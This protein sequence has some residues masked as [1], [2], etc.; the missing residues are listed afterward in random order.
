MKMLTRYLLLVISTCF[1][2]AGCKKDQDAS[3]SNASFLQDSCKPLTIVFTPQI[4]SGVTGYS[5]CELEYTG[6]RITRVKYKYNTGALYGTEKF[7]FDS[8]NKLQRKEFY[9]NNDSQISESHNFY[10]A[11]DPYIGHFLA[12]ADSNYFSNMFQLTGYTGYI[13]NGGTFYDYITRIFSNN[14]NVPFKKVDYTWSNGD[15]VKFTFIEPNTNQTQTTTVTYDT[16]Q[17]NKLNQLY[18]DLSFLVI[19][20]DGAIRG[21]QY[22]MQHF[23]LGKHLITKISTTGNSYYQMS[24]NITYTYNAQGL[25]S[26]IKLDGLIFLRFT[27]SCD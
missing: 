13:Y 25:V 9:L 19:N 26:E 11:W 22:Y 4:S 12:S 6:S 8:Q 2:V 1:A 3:S 5:K 18:P 17:V 16:A 14:P 7:I 24:G 20:N 15:P 21:A 27:Y 23:F 10:E